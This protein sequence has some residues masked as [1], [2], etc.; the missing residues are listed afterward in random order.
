MKIELLSV[1]AFWLLLATIKA[2]SCDDYKDKTT[3]EADASCKFVTGSDFCTNKAC[4]DHSTPDECRADNNCKYDD[5]N[6]SC[7]S[8]VC[9]SYYGQEACE[10]LSYCTY[11]EN[12][13]C[14]PKDNCD[15][16]SNDKESCEN[17]YYCKYDNVNTKCVKKRLCWLHH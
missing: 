11:N 1:L 17:L 6:G 4:V 9:S 10:A 8:I 7:V 13:Y 5:V 16:Y 14:V 12:S 3:C 15:T 2:T